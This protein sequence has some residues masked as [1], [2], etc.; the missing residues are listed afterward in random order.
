MRTWPRGGGKNPKRKGL[1]QKNLVWNYSKTFHE[2]FV[3]LYEY[4]DRF[5]TAAS[6]YQIQGRNSFHKLF[7]CLGLAFFSILWA[8]TF[9]V[10]SLDHWYLKLFPR[11][12][13]PAT[14]FGSFFIRKIKND[15]VGQTL[16]AVYFNNL[17]IRKQLTD[18]F[19]NLIPEE[20]QQK[21]EVA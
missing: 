4:L 2:I 21:V 15:L 5:C 9:F 19:R 13:S 11:Y 8:I 3:E 6:R 16:A 7:S 18:I 14:A 1:D 10:S 12:N 17:S 20:F